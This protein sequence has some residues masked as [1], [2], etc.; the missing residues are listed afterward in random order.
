M[1]TFVRVVEGNSLSA[2]ARAQ[3]LSLPAVSRQ[4]RAL[5]D[6]LGASLVARSTRRLHVTDAGRQ[7]YE[8]C[9]RILRE[10]D[11]ARES[12]QSPKTVRGTLVVSASMTFGSVVVIPRLTDLAARHPR[13]EIDLRL[14]DRLVD[15]IG[16]GIDV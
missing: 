11:A 2:A 4:L 5:E 9:V 6:E 15:L 7:W 12:I 3:R 14:E 8:H 1:Q 13:L 10:V 16:E